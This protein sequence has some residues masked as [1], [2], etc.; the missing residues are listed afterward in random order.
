M[1]AIFHSTPYD[2]TYLFLN[3][4]IAQKFVSFILI[5]SLFEIILEKR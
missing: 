3:G 5:C 1:F 2:N 4:K